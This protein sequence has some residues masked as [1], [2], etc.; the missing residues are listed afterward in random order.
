M[1]LKFRH[2][3]SHSQNGTRGRNAYEGSRA[4]TWALL[5]ACPAAVPQTRYSRPVG[6]WLL[7]LVSYQPLTTAPTRRQMETCC[8]R[9]IDS[10]AS[11]YGE[12]SESHSPHAPVTIL[13]SEGVAAAYILV[14]R[15]S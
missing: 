10:S 1:I 6:D 3:N 7:W 12:P 14:Q 9:D 4:V 8:L 11:K 13:Q 5:A 2:G 15:R